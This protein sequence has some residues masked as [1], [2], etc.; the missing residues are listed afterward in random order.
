MVCGSS[1]VTVPL[2]NIGYFSVELKFDEFPRIA[3]LNFCIGAC[4]TCASPL[5]IAIFTKFS[6]GFQFI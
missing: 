2:D 4:S 3:Y 1:N 5:K 6:M